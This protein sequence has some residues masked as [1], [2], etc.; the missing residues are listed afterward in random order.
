[1]KRIGREIGRGTFAVA[2]AIG[3]GLLVRY[4]VDYG[5]ALTW[6]LLGM[7]AGALAARLFPRLPR[8][9]QVRVRRLGHHPRVLAERDWRAQ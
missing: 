9:G 6:F 2:L 7:L 5:N 1:M 3:V 4:V 8:Q